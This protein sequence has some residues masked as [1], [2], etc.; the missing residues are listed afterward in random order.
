MKKYFMTLAAVL[1]CAMTMAVF[2][3]CTDDEDYPINAVEEPSAVDNGKWNVTEENM[4]KTV[5]PG[6]DFFMYCNGGYWK[7][8][9]VD[10]SN[11]FKKPVV[12]KIQ[13]WVDK[14]EA[15]L[16]IPSKAKMLKD[17]EKTDAATIKAQKEKLQSAIDR[18]DA[19]TT[20]EEAWKLM[21]ELMLEGYHTPFTANI[22][23]YSG[24]IGIVLLPIVGDKDYNAPS[25]ISEKDMTW[26]LANNPDV[27]ACVRPLK[28]AST[29]GFDNTKWPMLVTMFNTLGISLDDAYTLDVLPA[30]VDRGLAEIISGEVQELQ[31]MGVDEWKMGIKAT[32]NDDAVFF[33]DAALEAVNANAEKPQT[34]KEMLENV[35]KRF[36]KYEISKIF[37]DAYV[38]ADMKQRTLAYCEQLRQTFRERIQ[39]NVWMS[40]GSKQKA[41]EKLN[42]M[43]MNIG[44][45]EAW[46]E[47]GIADI[48]Q[49]ETLYDDICGVRQALLKLQFKLTGM[50]TKDVCFHHTILQSAL[51][52]VNAFYVPNTNSMNIYPAWMVA[53]C[54]DQQQNDAHNYATMVV[55]GHEIT[56]GF[57][58]SG[59]K[60]NKIGDLQDI[61]ANEAD[62]QEFQKRTQQLVDYYN[63]FDVMPFETGLKADG[64]ATVG[65]NVADLGGFFL[66]YDCYVKFLKKQGFKGNQLRLQLQRFYEAYSYLWCGKWTADFA[67]MRTGDPARPAEKDI[68]SMFR[69]RVNGIVTNTDD[70]Y[71]LFDVRST[72][73][74]YLAP[75]K[76]IRI[77]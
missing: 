13:E 48:S 64:A 71:N 74:L 1:C 70:W 24:K 30:L 57:D 5:R 72:D 77:W 39:Q 9:M 75:E 27:L 62:R 68:H 3:A 8:T 4:D 58:T 65:E 54:Y 18:V 34:R 59:A 31:E 11:P 22:F 16:T 67:L 41:T 52:A 15:A 60:Y 73:K 17:V 69:E 47:E 12:D 42:A 19:L 6:D 10:E 23:S 61:W 35:C 21:A 53:P 2:T 44:A 49:E 14:S 36:L 38:T 55:F 76:R 63:M 32:L 66:A 25:L 29:R 50:T 37:T 46:F 26:Q 51:T 43:V 56:H 20:K 7:N 28:G 40:V 33:D 45:P